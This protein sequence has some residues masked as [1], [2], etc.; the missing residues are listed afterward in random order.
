MP[1]LGGYLR[2][3]AM[4]EEYSLEEKSLGAIYKAGHQSIQ[5]VLK[6]A[7]RPESRGL[8][9]V[10]SWMGPNSLLPGFAAAGAQLCIFQYG[11]GVAARTVL[12]PSPAV[13]APLLWSTAN[14]ST[15]AKTGE[16]LDFYSGTVIEGKETI[17]AA[18]Q[19][20]LELVV[21]IASGTLTRG[22][23]IDYSA[24]IEVYGLD[25]LF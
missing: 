4:R 11:G 21:D 1:P 6:Y 15:R 12:D 14:P 24:P 5:G 13:V 8:Y 9:F 7:Q 18:G 19:R 17:E 2:P 10:D 16:S 3:P 25:P 22:E 20:L 23:T